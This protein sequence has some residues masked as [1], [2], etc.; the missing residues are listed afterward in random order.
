MNIKGWK[1]GWKMIE[2]GC[3]IGKVVKIGINLAGK[4]KMELKYS[5]RHR[6]EGISQI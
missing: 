5:K 6:L 2:N 3:K 1:K 4:W